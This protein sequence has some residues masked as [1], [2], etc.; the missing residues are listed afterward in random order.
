VAEAAREGDAAAIAAW[1]AYGEDLS[2]LCETITA[3]L[4]PDVIVI[5]GS[6]AGASDLFQGVFEPRLEQHGTRVVHAELGPAAGVIG[7]AALNMNGD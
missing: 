3:L 1:R 5:G 4:N 6:I 2:F 7:A